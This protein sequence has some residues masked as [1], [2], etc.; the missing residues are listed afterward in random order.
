MMHLGRL[1]REGLPKAAPGEYDVAAVVQW[2]LNRS[3]TD[4]RETIRDIKY[5]LIEEKVE[6]Q[7]LENAQ[8]RR[9]LLP[10]EEVQHM[11]QAAA[12][13]VATQLDGLTPRVVHELAAIVDVPAP[14]I[15][16]IL[17]RECRSIRENIATAWEAYSPPDQDGGE[18]SPTPAEPAR[19]RVG[20]P[21]KVSAARSARA[22][23]VAK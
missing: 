16:E 6:A 9:E 7:R 15:Q 17:F 21:R 19:R 5:R 18:D 8:S 1:V 4:A 2:L 11:I 23:K 20:R 13:A 3:A 14:R 12:V 22:R 10:V